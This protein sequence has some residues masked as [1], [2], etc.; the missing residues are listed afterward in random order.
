MRHR[1]VAAL[2]VVA[3]AL[4]GAAAW[5]WFALS[6]R[7]TLEDA[8]ITFRYARNLA[9]GLGFVYN[10]G[11]RVLGTTTPL[12]TLMLAALGRVFGPDRIPLISSILMPAFGLAAGL[13]TYASLASL[14]FSRIAAAL[15]LLLFVLHPFVIR[16]SVG[17]METPLVLFLMALGLYCLARKR[18]VAATAA[19]ALLA[20]C[21][22]DGIIWGGI[23]VAASLLSNYRRPLRQASGFAAVVLPWVVF[24]TLYFGSAIPNTMLAKG[25][26]RPGREQLLLDPLHFRRLSHWYL[27]GTGLSPDHTL[28]W[29]WVG[30][31]AAGVYAVIRAKRREALLLPLFPLAYAV[32]MYLGRAPMYQWY[33]L[34][35]L[36]CCL[37]LVGIGCWRLSSWATCPTVNRHWRAAVAVCAIAIGVV[38]ALGVTRDLPRRIRRA[39][40]FQDNEWSL[41]RGIGLWLNRNTPPNASIAMEA[42]GYQG[43]FAERRVIDMAGIVTPR[44]V[45]FKASTGS[46]GALFRRVWTEFKPD[47]IVLRSFEVDENRHFNGGNLFESEV[48]RAHFFTHYRERR[49]FSAPHPDIAPL[50][51]HLTLYQRLPQ[52]H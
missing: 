41:R 16:T 28:F 49:R 33:L 5:L 1:I 30:L 35:M 13:F 23:L 6:T 20:I 9:R 7:T 44:V 48:E 36:L 51:T 42:I 37:F 52:S 45:Q 2:P 29:I 25:V 39:R 43:Y 15:G 19:A 31:L 47:Y 18:P 10:P 3:T 11:E 26:V 14:G 22:L 24:A 34:P 40:D 4:I 12:L 27:S 46:N 38:G 8:Y 21:R 50:V 17:G 32:L